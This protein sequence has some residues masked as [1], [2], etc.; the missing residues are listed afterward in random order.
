MK[1]VQGRVAL[2]VLDPVVM[3]H[4]DPLLAEHD[5]TK[6][7]ITL[8]KLEHI[9]EFEGNSFVDL[10]QFHHWCYANVNVRKQ[11]ISCVGHLIIGKKLFGVFERPLIEMPLKTILGIQLH[12]HTMVIE[13]IV[14]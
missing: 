10:Q 3:D 4:N 13:I 2:V 14:N 7:E 9:K 1:T 12:L 6:G 5:V 8:N 11:E